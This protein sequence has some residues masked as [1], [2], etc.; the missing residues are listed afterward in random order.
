[1]KQI[2]LAV[3]LISITNTLIADPWMD[4]TYKFPVQVGRNGWRVN[5]KLHY[6]LNRP[7]QETIIRGRYVDATRDGFYIRPQDY[8]M[9][10][11]N[12]NVYNVNNVSRPMSISTSPVPIGIGR[13]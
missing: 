5:G 8:I 1:M 11:P 6:E 3:L 7:V 9:I 10:A 12:N 4:G 13:R 2:L